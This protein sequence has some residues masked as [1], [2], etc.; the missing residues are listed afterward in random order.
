[1]KT[2]QGNDIPITEAV[3]KLGLREGLVLP[4]FELAKA[5]VES[6]SGAESNWIR[7]LPEVAAPDLHYRRATPSANGS[8]AS[9][10]LNLPDL[11]SLQDASVSREE[12]IAAAFVLFLSRLRQG[13]TIYPAL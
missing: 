4:Q 3:V 11:S 1:M 5:D 2:L 10:E 13:E 9:L 12:L 8:A 7:L 6:I